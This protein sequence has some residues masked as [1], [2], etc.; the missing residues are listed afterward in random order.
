MTDLLFVYGTLLRA[1]RGPMGEPQRGQLARDADFVGGA[2]V[3]GRLYDLGAYPGLYVSDGSHDPE[4]PVRGEV[5]RLRDLE[6]TFVWLDRYEGIG[7]GIA[8]SEYARVVITAKVGSEPSQQAVWA[9]VM[10]TEPLNAR[11]ISHGDWL[12][13]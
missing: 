13:R 9:Y 7:P 3:H 5:W 6:K 10:P 8:A 11:L 4:L 1:A 12:G 2:N